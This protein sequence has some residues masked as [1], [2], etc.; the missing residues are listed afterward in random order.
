MIIDFYAILS[1]FLRTAGRALVALRRKCQ[2]ADCHMIRRWEAEF[3]L[4][5]SVKR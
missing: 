3:L 4:R 1:F 2:S 5:F